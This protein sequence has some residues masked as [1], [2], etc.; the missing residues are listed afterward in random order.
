M[1]EE[2]K[3]FQRNEKKKLSNY[4]PKS[5]LVDDLSFSESSSYDDENPIFRINSIKKNQRRRSSSMG[6]SSLNILQVKPLTNNDF[7]SN[8]LLN[9]NNDNK[10]DNKNVNNNVNNNNSINN[11]NIYNNNINNNINNNFNFN[12]NNNFMINNNNN[13]LY[14][15]LLFVNNKNNTPPPQILY[16]NFYM[17]NPNSSDFLLNRNYKKNLLK[18]KPNLLNLNQINNSNAENNN[19]VINLTTII[20]NIQVNSQYQQQSNINNSNNNNNNN[21]NNNINNFILT[22]SQLN[23]NNNNIQNNNNNNTINKFKIIQPLRK[24]SDSSLSNRK[25]IKFNVPNNNNNQKNYSQFSNNN[26][27]TNDGTN[28]IVNGISIQKFPKI[29]VKKY[30]SKIPSH[31]EFIDP[32]LLNINQTFKEFLNNSGH[33][34]SNIMC[35]SIGS[36]FLQKMLEKIEEDDIDEIFLRLN[37]EIIDLMC[38]NYGNYFLQQLILKCNLRQRLYLYD[39]LKNNFIEIANDIAG[40]H[41]IQAL[42][43]VISSEKEKDILKKNI[44]NNLM[45]LSININSTHVLQKIISTLSEDDREYINT[46]ISNNF[47]FLCKDV[48]GICLIKKFINEKNSEKLKKKCI[49]LL[50]E[51]CIEI[52]IDQYG[53]YAIQHALDQYGYFNCMSIIKIIVNNIVGLSNQKF[54]SNVVDK[55]ILFSHDN[56]YYNDFKSLVNIIFLNINNFNEI[57]QNKFGM[58]VILNAVKLMKTEEKFLVREYLKGKINFDIYEDKSKLEKFFLLLQQ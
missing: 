10:I 1:E 14:N 9:N 24:Q 33:K 20:N 5:L 46:F 57:S 42:I 39:K 23:N 29:P 58:F 37:D 41:C 54:S 8:D 31:H 19:N 45:K 50:T 43:D 16:N 11:N 56:N 12:N 36:R 44:E 32:D 25:S 53:N 34:L 18:Q 17:I 2:N 51:N 30:S 55:V 3:S 52:T 38:D 21:N 49:N 13:N 27:S 7:N 15:N 47:I 28:I 40:T 6:L 48:N 35:A 26:N 22:P 4:L